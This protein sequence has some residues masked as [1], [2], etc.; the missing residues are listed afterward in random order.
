MKH[1]NISN[2][3]SSL[4][5]GVR[6]N[7]F[8]IDFRRLNFIQRTLLNKRAGHK[9]IDRSVVKLIE[10]IYYKTSATVDLVFVGKSDVNKYLKHIQDIPHNQV[11]M[12][13]DLYGVETLLYSG[14][15]SYFVT[16]PFD[17][18]Q[19]S[20]EYAYDLERFNLLLKKGVKL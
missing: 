13:E 10:R 5:I 11:H 15:L 7:D 20:G 14:V 18:E 8:L 6:L 9:A 1:G 19:M 17:V 4:N 2:I 12:V 16:T 3:V